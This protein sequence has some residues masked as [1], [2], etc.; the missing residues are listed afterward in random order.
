MRVSREFERGVGEAV[1]A[2]RERVREKRKNEEKPRERELLLRLVATPAVPAVHAS[3]ER[4]RI[5]AM[6]ALVRSR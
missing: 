4:T 1:E 5:L 2:V 6:V 3:G